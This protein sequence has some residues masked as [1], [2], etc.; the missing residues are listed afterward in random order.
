MTLANVR[1][2]GKILLKS[3]KLVVLIDISVFWK[4]EVIVLY[5]F[6]QELKAKPMILLY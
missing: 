3:V 4:M 5:S 1:D 6:H 2:F